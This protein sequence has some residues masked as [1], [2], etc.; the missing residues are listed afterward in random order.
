MEMVRGRQPD[1]T[2]LGES[3]CP[4]RALEQWIRQGNIN[5]GPLFRKVSRAESVQNTASI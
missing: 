2:P 1:S 4:G 5:A 3:V